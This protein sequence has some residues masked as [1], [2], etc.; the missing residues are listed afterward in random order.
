MKLTTDRCYIRNM[1]MTDVD[2]LYQV[3]SNESVM[4][5][6]EPVFDMYQTK[7]FVQV[8]GLCEPH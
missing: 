8:A 4:H 5:Y 1:K 3:Y 7:E 2:D 6:I